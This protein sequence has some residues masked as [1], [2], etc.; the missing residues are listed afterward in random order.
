[1]NE[2]NRN[3]VVEEVANG[4]TYMK[5]MP[6]NKFAT[7]FDSLSKKIG[8]NKI[9]ID[10]LRQK[11]PCYNSWL[12]DTITL[13]SYNIGV[14]GTYGTPLYFSNEVIRGKRV[15]NDPTDGTVVIPELL[16]E[17][18]VTGKIIISINYPTAIEE[19]VEFYLSLY[20]NGLP[21]MTLGKNHSNEYY[22]GAIHTMVYEYD[23]G[24][25]IPVIIEQDDYI[26]L[27]IKYEGINVVSAPIVSVYG[28][29]AGQ[30]NNHKS[31]QTNITQGV[32]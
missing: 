11:E 30:F 9:Q 26:D 29:F 23:L 32:I 18:N 4:K 22:N 27:R 19:Y 10:K 5:G 16:G 24:S 1:M 12:Y 15:D 8:Y 3:I 20:K 14:S 28:Y 2:S 17:Y 6:M 13:N 7:F 21:Y 31:L 25:S